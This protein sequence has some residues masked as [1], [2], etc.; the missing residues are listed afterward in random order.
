MPIHDIIKLNSQA[1]GVTAHDAEPIP[2]ALPGDQYDTDSNSIL[3]TSE[4]RQNP[5]CTH[6]LTCGGC[7]LQHATDSFVQTWKTDMTARALSAQRLNP[8]FK[9]TITSPFNSRR[10]AVFSARRTKKTTQVGFHTRHSDQIVPITECH[11]VEP[12]ILD[13]LPFCHTLTKQGATRSSIL[14][15][16]VTTCQN[17]LD[18]AVKQAKDLSPQDMAT[19]AQA[20]VE[21]QVQRLSWNEELVMRQ[22]ALQKFGPALLEPPSGAF[23]QATKP[24]EAALLAAVEDCVRSASKVVDLFSGSGTFTLPIARS[25]D[26]HAVESSMDMLAALDRGWREAQGLKLVTCETRDLF[27]RPLLAHELNRFDAAIIDPPRA[28]AQ[29][30]VAELAQSAVGRIAYVSCNPVTFARDAKVLCDAGF[31]L[32]WVQ[33]VDQ[34]RWSH[35]VELAAQFTR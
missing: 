8:V 35:H 17:G 20:A 5:P 30:Q 22:P 28:G 10:R 9:K 15:I 19:F 14:K 34:F 18:I 12:A 25:A 6:F 4:H 33:V 16:T 13:A 31:V 1:Q 29:A 32:D 11:V 24:G 27:R 7:A 26:I 21:N 3:P 23:L 2:F